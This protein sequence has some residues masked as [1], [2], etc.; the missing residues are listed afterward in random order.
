MLIRKCSILR[1]RPVPL[2]PAKLLGLEKDTGSIEIGKRADLVGMDEKGGI[3]FAM[4]GGE[5]IEN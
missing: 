5:I 4:I 1:S 3:R 2:N